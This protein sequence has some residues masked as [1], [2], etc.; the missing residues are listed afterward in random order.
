[1][2]KTISQ[3]SHLTTAKLQQR[4]LLQ[5]GQFQLHSAHNKQWQ[6]RLHITCQHNTHQVTQSDQPANFSIT[7]C[8]K[9]QSKGDTGKH[10]WRDHKDSVQ[11]E[12][13]TIGKSW[14]HMPSHSNTQPGQHWPCK[15]H[16]DTYKGRDPVMWNY[17]TTKLPENMDL[18]SCVFIVYITLYIH[19]SYFASLYRQTKIPKV[20]ICDQIRQKGSYTHTVSRHTFYRHLLATSM[21]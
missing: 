15:Y 11:K 1:M 12:P 19:N 5:N 16:K 3:Y 6:T 4:C 9:Y 18:Y 10:Q 7:E 2:L 8:N 17:Y 14:F 21:D 20:H 13:S